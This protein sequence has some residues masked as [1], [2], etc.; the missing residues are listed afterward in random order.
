M[1][2]YICVCLFA[3]RLKNISPQIVLY[4]ASKLIDTKISKVNLYNSRAVL[5]MGY[6]VKGLNYDLICWSIIFF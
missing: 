3:C 1:V 2:K 6:T 4:V 5:M